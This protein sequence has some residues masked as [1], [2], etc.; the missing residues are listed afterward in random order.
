MGKSTYRKVERNNLKIVLLGSGNVATYLAKHFD[1]VA[2]VTQIW[3]RN[4]IHSSQLA[5][6]LQNAVAVEDIQEIERDADFYI[7]SVTD[8]AIEEVAAKLPEVKGIV[9]HTSGSFPLTK[10]LNIVKHSKCGVIYPLQTFSKNSRAEIKE[11]PFLI[12]GDTGETTAKL[13]TLA[14]LASENV[15]TVGSAMRADLHLA[16]VFANNFT[17]YILDLSNRY[18]RENTQFNIRVLKPLLIETVNKVMNIDPYNAQTGP[19]VRNDKEVIKTHLSKLSP[20][21]QDVYKYLTDKIIKDHQK[22]E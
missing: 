21:L 8:D 5:S 14:R 3:S 7:I 12:E 15:L 16:A 19:A 9:A 20:E 4:P 6:E 1:T 18:L 2:D 22:D 13:T 11:I 10:L 17:N